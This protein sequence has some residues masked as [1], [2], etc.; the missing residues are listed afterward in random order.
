MKIQ[1]TQ[2]SLQTFPD[3]EGWA[4]YKNLEMYL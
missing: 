2:P 1:R 4:G 3:T